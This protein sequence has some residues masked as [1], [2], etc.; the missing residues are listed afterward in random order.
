MGG[1]I[2]A[3]NNISIYMSIFDNIITYMDYLSLV[4]NSYR[5][6]YFSNLLF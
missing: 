1:I 6:T 4:M 5:V 2:S 3:V